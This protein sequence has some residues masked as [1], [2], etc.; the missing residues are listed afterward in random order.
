MLEM[1]RRFTEARLRTR[2][3]EADLARARARIERA[4][5][6]RCGDPERKIAS[7]S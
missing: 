7:G 4:L 5:G 1:Q 6:R 2:E 3:A